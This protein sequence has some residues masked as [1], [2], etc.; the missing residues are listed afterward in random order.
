MTRDGKE[1]R[2][3]WITLDDEQAERIAAGEMSAVGEFI[4]QNRKKFTR[5]AQKILR[6]Y[7][8]VIPANEYEADDCINQ[9]CVDFALYDFTDGRTLAFSIFRSF[10][11]IAHGGYAGKQY[12]YQGSKKIQPLSL[13]APVGISERSGERED[14]ARLSDILPSREPS[15]YEVVA[16]R[17]HIKEI[18]PHFYREIRRLFG[19]GGEHVGGATV[20]EILASKN[21]EEARDPLRDIIEEIFFGFS[22]EEVKAYATRAA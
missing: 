11:A 17:E 8:N 2:F 20:G 13:D 15:P 9:I 21:G 14:G 22:F 6:N 19:G 1:N 12:A 4:E 16:E 3:A 5:M 18:A 10:I 7:T